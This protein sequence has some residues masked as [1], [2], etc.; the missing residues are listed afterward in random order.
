MAFPTGANFT[1]TADCRDPL[2]PN[3]PHLTNLT[4]HPTSAAPASYVFGS[5]V[6]GWTCTFA[7]A[8]PGPSANG[9]YWAP[10]LA[11]T[12]NPI[13]VQLSTINGVGFTNHYVCPAHPKFDLGV[14][15]ARL[16]L[17]PTTP[18]SEGFVITVQNVGNQPL[19]GADLHHLAVTDNLPAGSTVIGYG[20]T[21][22]TDWSC[23]ST[24]TA[25]P[26]TCTY[27]GP[28]SS[29]A[30]F[31]G[32]SQLQIIGSPGTGPTQYTDP[33]TGALTTAPPKS[34]CAVISLQGTATTPT[35]DDTFPANNVACTQF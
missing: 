16:V 25:A 21:T 31:A 3:T 32:L 26:V 30:P 2:D 10:G 11:F 27:V 5:A 9:C 6:V 8:V 18:P 28:L 17:A 7:E 35:H 29:L 20:N 34:N 14:I 12:P 22:T 23:P 33:V 24:P 1:F 4:V 19:T 15:K 13:I